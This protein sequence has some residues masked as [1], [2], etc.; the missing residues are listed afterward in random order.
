MNTFNTYTQ[1]V[2]LYQDPEGKTI[3]SRTDPSQFAT[4]LTTDN[5]TIDTLRQQVAELKNE[6]CSCHKGFLT[7]YTAMLTI[8][9]F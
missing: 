2:G 5:D 8:V 4:N 7:I 6:V 1:M 3:F 9:V